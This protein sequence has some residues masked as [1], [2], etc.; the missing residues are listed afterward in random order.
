M[1]LGDSLRAEYIICVI[2]ECITLKKLQYFLL[3]LLA[4]CGMQ[5]NGHEL[6]LVTDDKKTIATQ[7]QTYVKGQLLLIFSP[8]VSEKQ[9][10][11]RIAAL[12]GTIIRMIPQ[13][14]FYQIQ[15]ADGLVAQDEMPKFQQINGVESVGLNYKRRMR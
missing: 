10:R 2:P 8:G 9:A 12:G 7:S 15:L 3:L 6:N 14:R 4:S 1:L 13:Q 5:E 11:E